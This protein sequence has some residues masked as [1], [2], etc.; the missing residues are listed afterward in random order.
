MQ[1]L[2]YEQ[3]SAK[4][5]TQLCNYIFIFPKVADTWIANFDLLIDGWRRTLKSDII[6][7]NCKPFRNN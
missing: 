5:C 2:L 6:F 4:N 7:G 3:W 1:Y